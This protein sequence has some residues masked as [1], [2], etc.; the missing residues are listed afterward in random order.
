[1][2][3]PR[4]SMV[5]LGWLS[6]LWLLQALTTYQ[7]WKTWWDGESHS[8]QH[9][10]SLEVRE[11]QGPSPHSKQALGIVKASTCLLVEQCSAVL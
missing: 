1:M 11:S 7:G 4:S 9:S 5:A 8:L 6:Q 10:F 2:V 3:F